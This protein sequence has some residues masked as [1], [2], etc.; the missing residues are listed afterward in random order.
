L[1]LPRCYHYP[2]TEKVLLEYPIDGNIVY[3]YRRGVGT[4]VEND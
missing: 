4:L 3:Y 1:I 2:Y